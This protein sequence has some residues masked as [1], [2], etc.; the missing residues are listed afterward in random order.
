MRWLI[1]LA[2]SL[3]VLGTIGLAATTGGQSASSPTEF[4]V[5]FSDFTPETVRAFS[6]FPLYSVGLRFDGLLLTRITRTLRKPDLLD[7]G[8]AAPELPDNRTN[9]VNF[10][11]GTCDSRASEGGCAPPLTIQVWPACDNSLADFYYNTRDGGP[12]R[13]YKLDTVR[14][15]PAARFAGGMLHVYA[16][17]VTIVIF[18]DSDE[19]RTRA[20][21]H[22]VAANSRA[23]AITS[24]DP[25][26][27]PIDGAMQG[28]LAC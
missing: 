8:E 4:Q 20:A 21:Q 16:G 6:D 15:V 14:G 13:D 5:A 22:L 19:L 25:L 12:S 2:M 23:G 27:A 3:G 10:I 7:V 26:P 9:Y 11:Y 28:K 1:V 18:G 24:D 17:R